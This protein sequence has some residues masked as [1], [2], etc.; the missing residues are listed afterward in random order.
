MKPELM[1][2]Y[3]QMILV[4]L[5]GVF[6]L[7]LTLELT[8]PVKL[9]KGGDP[10]AEQGSE[11]DETEAIQTRAEAIPTLSE[12]REI[13]ERPLFRPDRRPFVLEKVATE[14]VETPTREPRRQEE[15]FTL[16]AVIITDDKRLALIEHGRARKLK[17]VMQG[18][19]L[20]GWQID[21]VFPNQVTIQRGS[22]T[23]TLELKV[24]PSQPNRRRM[25]RPTANSRNQ[26]EASQESPAE[27]T[28]SGQP[29]DEPVSSGEETEDRDEAVQENGI[30]E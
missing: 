15:I 20:N 1:H 9:E 10:A 28:G 24:N 25:Q 22:E 27:S 11:A 3:L 29:D 4:G 26:K 13:I 23:R 7:T 30:D 8:L 19:V 18:E 6:L 21:R 12:Y 16:S 14:P 5:C 17:R 2:K